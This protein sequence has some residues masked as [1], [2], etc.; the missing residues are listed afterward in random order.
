MTYRIES[1]SLGSM[2]IPADALWGVHTA[3]ALDNFPISGTPVSRYSGLVVALAQ[4]KRAAARA[5]SSLGVL[6]PAVA[7]AIGLACQDIEEGQHHQHF[8]VDMIQGGAGTSTNMNAN[9]VIANLALETM[10]HPRGSYQ[11]LHPVDHVNKC[12]ST[13]DVYPTAI[14]LA[15]ITAVQELDHELGHLTASMREKGAAFAHVAKIG[16]TQLQDAVPMTLGQ[17][18]GAFAATIEEDRCRLRES[19][20]LMLECSL[21]ATAIGTGITA[22][23]GYR[24]RAI[25][26]L[27]EITGLPLVPAA[28]LLEAT[29]DVGVFM[30]VSGM[31]KRSAIK[32]SKISSDLRLL[33][34]GPQNGFGEIQLPP[35]Q[36]GSSIMPGKVNPVIPETL[37]QIAFAVA[38]ADT[39]VTMA[40]DN[41]QLQLNAFE[42][43]MAHALLQGFSWLTNGARILRTHCIQGITANEEL[44]GGRAAGSAGLATALIPALGYAAAAEVANRALKGR[45][46]VIDAVTSMGLMERDAAALILEG[47]STRAR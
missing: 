5:N 13:N 23:P 3:R 12:Q 36:A 45:V 11:Y 8:C 14:K 22:E 20:A 19:A 1:D 25:E 24:E 43:V 15:L 7:D 9:E 31:L 41:G 26:A 40:A 4:V 33:S 35:R 21:G 42:P 17:E 44:L 16:R 34:S 29:S 2:R 18:F 10:G 46:T 38:G 47:A 39:T 6:E 37:N 30:H 27:A 28:D 32:I